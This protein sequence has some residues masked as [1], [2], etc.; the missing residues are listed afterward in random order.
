M[1]KEKLLEIIISAIP[2]SN[3]IKDINFENENAIRFTWREIRFRVTDSLFVEE[4][5]F[6]GMLIKSS[7][8]ILLEKLITQVND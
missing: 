3:Q 6:D 4:V 7:L 8:S 1:N 5:E 2:F